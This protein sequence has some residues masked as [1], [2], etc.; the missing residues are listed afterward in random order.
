[1]KKLYQQPRPLVYLTIFILAVGGIV[2]GLSNL[3]SL[4]LRVIPER[5]P[6]Y[7]ELGN[8][9]TENK[10]DLKVVNKQ[11]KDRY[12][13][14]SVIS[15]LRGYQ[16]IGAEEPL[17]VKHGKDTA[18]TIYVKAPESGI[19]N[20]ITKITFRIQDKDNPDSFA[21]YDTRFNAPPS[22]HE[23]VEHASTEH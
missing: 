5:Q 7:T 6:L 9:I 20:E 8:E 10:Y 12:V 14:V 1:M 17:L 21:E 4:K 22:K 18:Y 11:E 23:A 16:L 3:G 15:A 13:Q 2:Y 19:D